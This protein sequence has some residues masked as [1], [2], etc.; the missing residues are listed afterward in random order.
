MSKFS[1]LLKLEGIQKTGG[2]CERMF[3]LYRVD[4]EFN[5]C[6]YLFL[7]LK[8]ILIFRLQLRKYLNYETNQSVD[9]R[10]QTVLLVEIG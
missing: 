1:F 2:K 9:Y 6:S 5:S 8:I 3:A 10:N 7:N 4:L